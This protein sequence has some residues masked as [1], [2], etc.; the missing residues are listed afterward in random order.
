MTGGPLPKKVKILVVMGTRSEAI[1]L[2]PVI[3]ELRRHQD[4]IQTVV[5]A[6]GQHREMLQQALKPFG[7]HPD[8]NLDV[9]TANQSLA[10]VTRAVLKGMDSVLEREKPDMVL[11]QGDTTT[12]M[13]GSLAAFYRRISLGHVEAGL[14]TGDRYNPFPEEINRRLTTH[15]ADFHFAPTELS[16]KNLLR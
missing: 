13:A 4:G 2:A 16:R 8:F 3:M 14:R 6:T 1:K 5:C 9:M 10:D 7:L 15:I 12:I 11:V